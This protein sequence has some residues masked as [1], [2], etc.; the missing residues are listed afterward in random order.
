[1][2]AL[3]VAIE[4][5]KADGIS[6]PEVYN[7]TGS[8]IFDYLVPNYLSAVPTEGPVYNY[9]YYYYCNINTVISTGTCHNDTDPNTYAIFFGTESKTFLGVSTRYC[10]TSDGFFP[11]EYGNN[12]P[13]AKCLQR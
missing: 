11:R 13:G 2:K 4:M 9:P 3:Q 10:M 6:P 1:M 8:G 5:A 12:G 7:T